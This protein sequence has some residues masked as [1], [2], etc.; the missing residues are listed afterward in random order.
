M[1]PISPIEPFLL[2]RYRPLPGFSDRVCLPMGNM[3]ERIFDSPGVL[4]FRAGQQT[5]P[6]FAGK[7]SNEMVEKLEL[8]DSTFDNF[9]TVVTHSRN[10]L[11]FVPH[12][13]PFTG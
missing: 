12:N 4:G 3:S 13:A 8:L 5:I 2:Y 6:F 10:L 11:I 7:V 1:V 9:L